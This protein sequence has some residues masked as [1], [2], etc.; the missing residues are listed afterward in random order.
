[1][2]TRHVPTA[3]AIALLLASGIAGAQ[4]RPVPVV[5]DDA[6]LLSQRLQALDADMN[7]AGV[8]AYERLRA[9]QAVQALSVARSQQRA[10]AL[11]LA[12][13]RVEIAET[14]SR[15]ALDQR[16]IERLD[17]TRSELLLEATRQEA[18]RARAEAER[19]RLEARMQAEETQRLREA[20]EAEALARQEAEDL[21]DSVGGAEAERLRAARAREAELARQEAELL[22]QQERSKSR[23]PR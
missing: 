9:Q 22:R 12:E 23:D 16:E 13:R 5:V 4:Q 19:L 18:A 20:A 1:M 3:W 11:A 8:A 17:R 21:I 15:T 7:L 10:D 6:S 2:N 14:A